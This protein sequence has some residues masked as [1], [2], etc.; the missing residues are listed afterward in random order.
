MKAVLDNMQEIILEKKYSDKLK[1]GM[2]INSKLINN[3]INS[4]N[5]LILVKEQ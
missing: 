2:I 5:K 4:E 3:K 1:N